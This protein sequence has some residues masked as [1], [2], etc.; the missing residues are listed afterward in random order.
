MSNGSPVACAP[1]ARKGLCGGKGLATLKD[2]VWTSNPLAIQILGICS[3]LAVT[4]R[5][6]QPP[7]SWA[8]ALIFVTGAFQPVRLAAAQPT[9][10]I[11]SA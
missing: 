8:A 6:G 7:W 9:S 5:R 3:S 2:G 11:G 1:C 10:P 4:N